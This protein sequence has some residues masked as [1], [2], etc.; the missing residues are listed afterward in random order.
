MDSCNA[1]RGLRRL[2]R[3]RC[4]R[5]WALAALG[6]LIS[7]AGATIASSAAD[8]PAASNPVEALRRRLDEGEAVLS[9]S[10]EGRGYLASLLQ[11]LD[12]P[13]ES[14]LL[15]FSAS[16]LQF[17][18]I[19]QTTP[20]AI[21]H[22]DGLSVGITIGGNLIEIITPDI[23]RGVSFYV[24]D[25][26][27]T[28]Q[29]RLVEQTGVCLVCHGLVDKAAPGLMVA[30]VDTGPGGQVLVADPESL[31]RG[32]G[33]LF[34]LTDDRTPF[35]QRYGGWY[36]TG[37][38]GQMRHRGNVTRDP[39]N[40]TILPP[41][42]LNVLDLSGRLD[43][44]GYLQPGSDIVSLLA[45]EHEAGVVNQIGRINALYRRAYARTSTDRDQGS[46]PEID[47]AVEDLVARLTFTGQPRLPSP[48]K[49]SSNFPK[50]FADRGPFDAKGRSLRQFDLEQRVFR[51]PLSFM[52]NSSAF[53]NL[54][55]AIKT[56]VLKRLYEILSGADRSGDFAALS[57][58]RARAA[59]N[60]L[61]ATTSDLPDFWRP[62]AEQSY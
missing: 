7:I 62:V 27:K 5:I 19:N 41:G 56:R 22:R 24:L 20:R 25:V 48:V 17:S 6:V 2:D 58:P 55:P 29:P 54:A 38:T 3:R 1:D 16:S 14:Q 13:V 11:A 33:E 37:D 8:E 40:M 23:Q 44:T 28:A 32:G 18:H 43:T 49:G 45:L 12:I 61:A 57:G 21:Y 46:S 35:E 31:V 34:R 10:E 50:V 36:V 51:Y 15:V 4:R 47:D 42:G 30:D 26:G 53:G 9:W 52:I 60:I 39:D 59:I